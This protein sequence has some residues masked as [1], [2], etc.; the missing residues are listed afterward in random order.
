M[1]GGSRW[2]TSWSGEDRRAAGNLHRRMRSAPLMQA[3]QIVGGVQT[4][5]RG[6]SVEREC[7]P[8][9][10]VDVIKLIPSHVSDELAQAL[11]RDSRGLF[12]QHLSFLAFNRDRGTK[13][14]PNPR[15]ATSG[16][17]GAWTAGD[18]PI[19]ARQRSGVRAAHCPGHPSVPGDDGC[20]HARSWSNSSRTRRLSSTSV[21]SLAT[22]TD[23]RRIRSRRCIRAASTSACLMASDTETPSAVSS[24]KALS[25]RSS[26]RKFTTAM[27]EVYYVA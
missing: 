17:S 19:A 6:R 18:R 5:F 12:D 20:H 25:D 23:S 16:R 14:S 27:Y 15:T 8:E 22:S 7:Q 10:G 4:D 3:V 2:S 24:A 1:T 13:Y 26:V 9:R 11:G 21:G